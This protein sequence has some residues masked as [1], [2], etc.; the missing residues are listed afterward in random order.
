MWTKKKERQQQI[1][2]THFGVKGGH[3][4][5]VETKKLNNVL[6]MGNAKIEG[7]GRKPPKSSLA[8]AIPEQAAY[9]GHSRPCRAETET[10]RRSQEDSVDTRAGKCSSPGRAGL[11]DLEGCARRPRKDETQMGGQRDRRGDRQDTKPLS[12]TSM[13]SW[14]LLGRWCASQKRSIWTSKADVC[15]TE[16]E[17]SK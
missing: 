10:R 2:F 13:E 6:L 4:Q 11:E 5:I 8:G 15:R 17:T 14:W 7:C 9:R 1:R 3:F 16:W 12:S